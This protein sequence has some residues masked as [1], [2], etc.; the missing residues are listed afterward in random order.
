MPKH[1]TTVKKLAPRY[2]VVIGDLVA[3]RRLRPTNRRAVQQHFIAALKNLN[4][5]MQEGLLAPLTITLGDEFEGVLRPECAASLLPDLIWNLEKELAGVSV[6][7]GIGIGGIDTDIGRD[8]L[9]MDGPAF[10]NA[11]K[12]IEVAASEEKLGGLFLGFGDPSDM[13]LNGMARVLHH[14]REQWSPQQRRLAHLLREGKR[15]HEAA[16]ILNISRQ[17]VSAYARAA[18]WAAYAEGE[19]AWRAALAAAAANKSPAAS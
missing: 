11:R 5:S 18:D 12:A 3:S 8:P 16:D 10:H 15:Q 4:R 19:A 9:T 7:F 2:M 6:R 1:A 13:I 17:A 14:H